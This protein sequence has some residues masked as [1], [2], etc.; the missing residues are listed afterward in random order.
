MGGVV[1]FIWGTADPRG[2][3]AAVAAKNS[4]PD[5]FRNAA[6]VLEEITG[7]S[8]INPVRMGGVV[9]FLW[10]TQHTRYFPFAV[11]GASCRHA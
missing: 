4:P 11:V 9:A 2:T 6:T 7:L 8:F 5:C 3:A 1:A 10:G